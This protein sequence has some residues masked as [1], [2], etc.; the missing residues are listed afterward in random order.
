MQSI[1]G[2]VGIVGTCMVT[3]FPVPRFFFG[4]VGR[5]ISTVGKQGAVGRNPPV[6]FE[7]AHPAKV[8]PAAVRSPTLIDFHFPLWAMKTHQGLPLP[9]PFCLIVTPIEFF[10][11]YSGPRC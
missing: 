3:T 5:A 9:F 10:L 6:N 2:T 11:N 7:D 8:A 1:V 4:I